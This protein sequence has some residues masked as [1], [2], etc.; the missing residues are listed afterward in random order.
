[1]SDELFLKLI[2]VCL[3]VA[4]LASQKRHTKHSSVPTASPKLSLL[5]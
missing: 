5:S 4:I 3:A 2:S 1:M